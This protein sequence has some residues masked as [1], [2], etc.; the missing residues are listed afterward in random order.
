MT[1]LSIAAWTAELAGLPDEVG[2]AT[3]ERIRAAGFLTQGHA[4]NICP[5]RTGNLAGS[6]TVGHPSGRDT[7][8]GD[9]EI[10]IGPTAGYGAYVEFGTSRMGARPYMT[11]AAETAA[12]WLVEELGKIGQP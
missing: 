6:I 11:P 4:R 9:L 10:E 2:A 8:P 5:K 12:A 7:Q 1:V 3:S